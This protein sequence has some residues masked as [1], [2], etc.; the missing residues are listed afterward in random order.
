MEAKLI[1]VGGEAK[2]T[3]I[4]LKLPTII[5]RGRGASLTLP[6]PLV[7][8][9]HCEVY[10]ASGHLMVRDLGSLNGTFVNNQR[11]TEAVLPSGELLT[12]G[13]VTFRASYDSQ[14]DIAPPDAKAD[15]AQRKA[16]VGDAETIPTASNDPTVDA[17]PVGRHREA[18]AK[19]D[20]SEI[21]S[22]E[23]VD[24]SVEFDVDEVQAVED[25]AL[26]LMEDEDIMNV[27]D[28]DSTPDPDMTPAQ[29]VPSETEDPDD[30]DLS[31][32]LNGLR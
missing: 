23:V 15:N 1:V 12:V 31:S 17:G 22:V 26:E 30:E 2:T 24:S 27:V 29:D 14:P 20:S 5:G 6:H 11:I 13:T 32:F 28:G 21:D 10:E 3:E 16:A 9:Q 25:S 8:R 19:D 4:K 7:S 18:E